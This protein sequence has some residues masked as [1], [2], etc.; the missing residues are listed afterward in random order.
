MAAV[1]TAVADVP[2][3]ALTVILATGRKWFAW[4]TK[5]SSR[6][7]VSK[8]P[9]VAGVLSTSSLCNAFPHERSQQVIVVGAAVGEAVGAAEG[10]SV[11]AEEGSAVGEA[12]GALLGDSVG[13]LVGSLV[14]ESVG[15][16]VWRQRPCTQVLSV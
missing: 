4:C 12:V 16:R 10:V 11:G 3:S 6:S 5:V 7:T 14:G 8:A 15:A 13:E 2:N 1:I 9:T